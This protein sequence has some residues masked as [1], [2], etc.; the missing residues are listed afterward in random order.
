FFEQFLVVPHLPGYRVF[1]DDFAYLFNSYYVA[2]GPRHAR[3]Q[4]GLI[5]RPDVAGVSEYRAYVDAAVERLITTTDDA[6]L[7]AALRI[8]A[9]GR[10]HEQQHQELLLT[11]ILHA[12]AQTPAAPAYDV[13]WRPPD[14]R[15]TP[16]GFA[17]VPDGIQTIGFSGGG[18]SFDN[19]GPAHRVFLEPL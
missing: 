3:P 1:D 5:T 6:H 11:D 15:Q 18:Y 2:A 9:T 8:L 13:D 10:H 4:R 14:C 16:H 7:R 17:E 19:E 12:F